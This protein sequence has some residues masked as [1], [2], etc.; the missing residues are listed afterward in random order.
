MADIDFTPTFT[1]TPWVD[2][3][4]R[5]QAGGT[6]GFNVRFAALEN[7]L[8]SISTVVSGIDA[9]IDALEAGS[10]PV[11][12]LLTI[13]PVMYQ[14]TTGSP[15]SLDT[16]GYATKGTNTACTGLAPV[17]LPNGVT[18]SSFRASGQKGG[19]GLLQIQL[20]RA[21]STGPAT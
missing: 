11:S 14:V 5:V 4:D 20:W 1:H 10:G 8:Q 13:A 15:W 9:A 3:K 2:N 16:S 6:N 17:T 7:D 12:H 19:A 18:L 21:H